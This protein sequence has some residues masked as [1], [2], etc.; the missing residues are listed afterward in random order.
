MPGRMI[1]MTIVVTQQ[2]SPLA[3]SSVSILVNRELLGSVKPGDSVTL[4]VDADVCDVE[5]VC[6]SY[7]SWYILKHDDHLLIRWS[8]TADRMELV[9]A[10]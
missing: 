9:P 4:K 1:H 10:K 3:S 2:D 7:R 5:A 6:G 8:A